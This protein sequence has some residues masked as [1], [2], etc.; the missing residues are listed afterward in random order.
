M[1]TTLRSLRIDQFLCRRLVE[2]LFRRQ[3]EPACYDPG[4][5]NVLV[6]LL[7]AQGQKFI[8]SQS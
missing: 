8:G 6:Q 3:L 7:P 5:C 4:H 1:L 2:F